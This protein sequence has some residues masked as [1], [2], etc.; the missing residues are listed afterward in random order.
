MQGF[1]CIDKVH[2]KFL[3]ILLGVR[4]QTPNYSVYGELGRFPLS[5]ICKE[6]AVKFWLELIKYP[7]SLTFQVLMSEVEVTNNNLL[8]NQIIKNAIGLLT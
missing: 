4:P 1:D 3:K 7:E 5:V 6:R 2:I 8:R